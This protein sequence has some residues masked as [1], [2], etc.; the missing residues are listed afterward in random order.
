MR[1]NARQ[2]RAS[3][4]MRPLLPQGWQRQ[5]A[6]KILR[7]L[8]R[9]GADFFQIHIWSFQDG[10]R[11]APNDGGDFNFTFASS[12]NISRPVRPRQAGFADEAGQMQVRWRAAPRVS[13]CENHRR[14]ILRLLASDAVELLRTVHWCDG[15]K[16]PGVELGDDRAR[17][18]IAAVN[19]RRLNQ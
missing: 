12:K 2:A 8:A 4:N 10:N 9:T 6:R 7:E 16:L 3:S 14:L 19:P 11:L 15:A 17:V 5:C 13:A 18:R 1:K